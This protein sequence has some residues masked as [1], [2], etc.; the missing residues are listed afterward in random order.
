[1]FLSIIRFSAYIF[2]I[3]GLIV[4]LLIRFGSIFNFFFLFLGLFL[5]AAAAHADFFVSPIG[6]IANGLLMLIVLS[7]LIVEGLIVARSFHRAE[8]DADYV[9]VLGS[10]MRKDGPS[11]DFAA[12]LSAAAEYLKDNPRSIAIICGAKGRNEPVSEAEGGRAY[13]LR[14][15]IAK[16][17]IIC[18]DQSYTTSE[19]IENAGKLLKEKKGDLSEIKIVIVSGYYHLYRAAYLAERTGFEKIST[20]GSSGLWILLPHYYAREYFGLIKEVLLS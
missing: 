1:M 6:R 20:K 17:R 7:F 4:L 18:E 10:Q 3:Y 2:I 11:M 9:I 14:K 16:E 12:R 19:N 5:L 15:G 8:P 13:L